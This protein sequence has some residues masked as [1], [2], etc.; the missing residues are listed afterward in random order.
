[1]Y[2]GAKNHEPKLLRSS[3]T[4]KEKQ[5][6]CDKATLQARKVCKKKILNL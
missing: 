4:G 1:M 2:Y 6:K 5:E 3:K